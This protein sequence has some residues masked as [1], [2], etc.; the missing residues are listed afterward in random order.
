LKTT[1]E[2]QEK[3]EDTK[4]LLIF[5]SLRQGNKIATII[6]EETLMK[7]LFSDCS[8]SSIK[9][10]LEINVFIVLRPRNVIEKDIFKIFD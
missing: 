10:F 9:L 5:T 3:L 4:V 8:F 2:Y 6:S 7:V 1:A